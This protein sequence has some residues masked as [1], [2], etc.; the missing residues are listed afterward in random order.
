MEK[1]K[2]VT[3]RLLAA[4]VSLL[5]LSQLAHADSLDE[6][7]SRYAQ[8]KQAWD[9]RQMDVVNQ[10]MPTL[11]T[12]PL[13]PYLQYRQITDDLMN[14]PALVVTNF[15][16]ANPTLPPARSLKSRFVNELARRD[17]W[18]G[19][20]AFSPEKPTGTEAQCNYYYAK[21]NVGQTQEAWDGA[22][23]LWL[24]GKSQPNACDRLFGAWRASGQQDPLAY[25]ERIR[26][27]MKAGNTSLVRVLAQQMPSDYQ[28]I[29]TAV[30]ALANDPNSVMTFARTTG[31]TDFTRQMAAVAFASVARQDVENARLMIPSLA[32][33][34]QLNEDQIQELRDI[35]AWRLMGSDVTEEQAIWRDDAIMRSQSTSLVERRVRMALGLGDRRGLNTWLARLP[36]EAK[37][38]DEW[39]YWQAD[40][41]LERGR[42][43]EAK[44]I[45]R[46]LMQ[47]RGFYP[48]VAAQRLGEEYT[49]RIDKAPA[50]L[51]PALTSGPEMARVR[52][53]MYWN[54]DNTARSEWANLVTSKTKDQQAQLARYAFNQNW[55]DLSVQATIAGKLWDQLE[56][57]FPLAYN[58]LFK[59]YISGKDIPQSYAMAIARQESAW[60]PK[61]GSPVGARGLMQIMPGTATHTVS[62]FSIPGYS[63]PSQLLDPEMNINIGTSYLQYVYQ[64]FGNNRIFASA[65]YNAG[66]GRVRTWRGNSGGRIDAVA[67]VESIPF[68]ETRGYVKTVLSYDAY[69]RYFM[70]QKDALLSDAEWKLRY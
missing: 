67:F 36:M 24:S 1:A 34:Q 10:L 20:L 46:S 21:W 52:E 44:D 13:Y 58:D 68:S 64:Q 39:R 40:L 63:G 25:L 35:V 70:G 57:R 45:L 11:T 16:A 14:Q 31:A 51:D 43:D 41:L 18:R 15:I 47:Q 5:T 6:Q 56:E 23:A 28:T 29:A 59:R 48:M 9:N 17:D 50:N 3:W 53:L 7:R 37:E 61:A 65:A 66:P 27:A 54:M 32:Q 69:Y 12:Y 55:W 33:A 4:G 49:F 2:T 26:L 42:D 38:K 19:L 30:I 62:M 22:K 60:N 8:T